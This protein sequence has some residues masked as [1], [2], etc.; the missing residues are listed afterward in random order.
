MS[1]S[2][3]IVAICAG[4]LASLA[5]ACAAGWAYNARV[6]A[7]PYDTSGGMYAGGEALTALAAF[8]A[9]ALP[10]TL[11]ALLFLRS[12]ERFWHGVA[13]LSLAFASAG[14]LA[15]LSPLVI[16]G[17]EGHPVLWP[18]GLLWLAQL[19]GVPLWTVAFA[20]LAVIAPTWRTRRLLLAAT[21][22]ELVI[23]VCAAIHWFVPSPPF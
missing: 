20:L 18:L 11:V 13:V 9:L 14:L 8:A 17:V 10:T 1:R 3:K 4:H 22:I 19:L 21:G 6:S 2:A 5:A 23:A 12:Q 15:V 7:L 16:P